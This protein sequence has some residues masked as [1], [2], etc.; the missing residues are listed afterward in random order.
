MIQPEWL[1]SLFASIDKQDTDTFAEFL[2]EDTV[3]VFSNLPPVHGKSATYTMVAGF[4]QS[5]A[6]LRHELIENWE[7]GTAVICR[8]IVTYTR[9]SGTTLTVPFCNVFKMRD[10]KIAEY[11]IHMDVSQLYVEAA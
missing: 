1:V 5:I 2:A 4:F 6:G 10:G 7:V 8:G 11:L 3:F 9:H